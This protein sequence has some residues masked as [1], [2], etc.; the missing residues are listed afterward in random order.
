VTAKSIAISNPVNGSC[1]SFGG[2]GAF[3]GAS[4]GA[5]SA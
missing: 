5:P 3:S 4:G 1:T 2:A